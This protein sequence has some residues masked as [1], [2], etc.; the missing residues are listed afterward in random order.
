MPWLKKQ[1]TVSSQTQEQQIDWSECAIFIQIQISSLSPFVCCIRSG[2]LASY[3]DGVIQRMLRAS[4]LIWFPW[5]HGGI[6]ASRTQPH[7]RRHGWKASTPWQSSK[8]HFHR[9]CMYDEPCLERGISF[10]K[11][12]LN[13][14]W[15]YELC[16]V[17]HKL[18]LQIYIRNDSQ[19]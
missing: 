7:H 6:F 17:K 18:P 9:C 3:E 19:K 8:N 11:D 5:S 12:S 16:V 10:L 4:L 14:S 2:N 1:L 15:T 13:L